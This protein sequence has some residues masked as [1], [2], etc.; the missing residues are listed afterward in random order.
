MTVSRHLK[1]LVYFLFIFKFIHFSCVFFFFFLVKNKQVWSVLTCCNKNVNVRNDW[2]GK[3]CNDWIV[4]NNI[5]VISVK[6]HL[7]VIVSKLDLLISALDILTKVTLTVI[8]NS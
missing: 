6:V 4:W 7:V 5:N 8:P 2:Q 1:A 3:N